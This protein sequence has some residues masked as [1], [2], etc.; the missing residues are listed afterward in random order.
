MD[1]KTTSISNLFPRRC[2]HAAFTLVEILMGIGVGGLVLL[3]VVS[4]T[5]YCGKSFAA[6]GNYVDLNTRSINALDQMTKDVRQMDYL[7]SYNT[8]TM[9]FANGTNGGRLTYQYNPTAKTLERIEGSTATTLLTG[10]DAFNFSVYQ[11]NPFSNYSFQ[12]TST[13][14]NCKLINVKWT[15]SRS[16]LGTMLH[17]ESVQTAKIVIRKS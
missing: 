9:V 12:A 17:T 10:C 15:C 4:M 1:C 6:M 2:R 11:R 14:T 7:V 8:T 16:I 5:M 13:A 3:S